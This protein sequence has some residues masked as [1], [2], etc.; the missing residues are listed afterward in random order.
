M[1]IDIAVIGKEANAFDGEDSMLFE[2]NLNSVLKKLSLLFFK[3]KRK[4][5]FEIYVVPLET[6]GLTP[7]LKGFFS[8]LN[9]KIVLNWSE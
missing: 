8:Q 1:D 6:K 7:L 9:K 5:G 4:I 3:L 2:N